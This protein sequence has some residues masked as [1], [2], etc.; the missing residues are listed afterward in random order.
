MGVL[1]VLL[2]LA[3]GICLVVILSRRKYR[4]WPMFALTGIFIVLAFVFFT[5]SSTS[6]T[7]D[8]PCDLDGCQF[9]APNTY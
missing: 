1:A 8:H 9:Y 3:A 4:R 7:P 6:R 2:S 5:A